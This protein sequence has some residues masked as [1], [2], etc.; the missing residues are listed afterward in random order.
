MNNF[1]FKRRNFPQLKIEEQ[2]I[3]R[4]Y[5]IKSEMN[6]KKQK[7]KTAVFQFN[8]ALTKADKR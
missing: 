6:E 3:R 2:K 8:V 4:N 5:E 7:Q 1:L